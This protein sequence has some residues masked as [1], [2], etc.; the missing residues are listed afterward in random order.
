MK[1]RPRTERGKENEDTTV[2]SKSNGNNSKESS[3]TP[4][5]P[6]KSESKETV[7]DGEVTPEVPPAKKVT[8][9]YLLPKISAVD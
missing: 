3:A 9:L 7:E 6:P 4:T 5:T 2:S 8:L 1:K